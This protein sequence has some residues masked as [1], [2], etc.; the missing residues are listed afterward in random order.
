MTDSGAGT[1]PRLDLNGQPWGAARSPG[2]TYQQLL[3]TD[4]HPVPAVLRIEHPAYLGSDDID[5]ARYTSRAWHDLEVEHLWRTVWQYTCREDEIPDVGDYYLYEIVNDSYIVIRTADGIKAYV[6]ACLHRGRRLK[7]YSGHCSEIRCP[8][9]GFA[10]QL[11]GALQD[12]PARWDFPH[13][14][15]DNFS[16]PEAQVGTWAGFVFIN[17]NPDNVES[18]ADFLGEVVNHFEVWKLEHRYKQA[19]VAKVI[20]ANWKIAQEA[21]CEAYHVNATHPQIMPYLGDTNSQVDVWHNFARV[22]TPG[23]TPS[24]LLDYEPSQDEMMRSMMDVRHD[25]SSPVQLSNSDDMRTVAAAAS[26][27]RWRAAAGDEWVESL[28]DAEMM[29]SI[30]YTVFP[31]FHPWGAFNRIVYRF[32]PNGDDHRSSIME[33]IFLAPYSGEKP[34]PAPV[35]WLEDF[36]SF[37]DA[38]ELGMLGKVFN[39]DLFNMPNVQRGLETTRKPGVTLAN[40]QESK[41]RWLHQ[42]LGEWI[43]DHSAVPG[44][45]VGRPGRS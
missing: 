41:V 33:C 29:D 35:H 42:R 14:D 38:P 25:Q 9:H 22:I 40:Y 13:I 32:R 23:G 27:D 34:P 18:L 5:V 6:N 43:D 12:V 20:N 2:T 39:Q 8:F 10:W 16:L 30:D 36:E 3:D 37:T 19:H 7:D 45:P 31:N 21:F 44:T 15:A 4:S 1:A 24:P 17:P 28:S 11:D 26:R